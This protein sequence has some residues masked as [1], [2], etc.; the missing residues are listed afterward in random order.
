[1]TDTSS[2]SRAFTPEQ[3]I[4]FNGP[5]GRRRSISISLH[6]T[7]TPAVKSLSSLEHFDLPNDNSDLLSAYDKLTV[8]KRTIEKHLNRIYLHKLKE[9]DNLLSDG[10]NHIDI[11][12]GTLP[13]FEELAIVTSRQHII[14]HTYDDIELNHQNSQS[15]DLTSNNILLCTSD[16]Y[17]LIYDDIKT[18]LIL[19]NN[20]SYINSFIWD[21]NE[22]G[23]PCDLTYSYYLDLYCIITNRGLFTW[24]NE[25]KSIP[26]HIDSIR[27]ISG[28]RLWTIAS[29]DTKSDVFILFKLGSY[30]ERWNSIVGTKSWQHIQRWSNHDLFERNDQ[31]IRTIRMTSNYVV[32][33]V[34]STKTSEW[35][36]DLL[37]YHLQVL[38]RGI[39]ID[40]LD[41]YSSCLLSNFGPEQFL[42]ID[43]NCHSLFLL[44]SN[45]SIKLKTDSII[46]KRIKNAVLMNNN[47]Q[48]WLVVRLERP[49]QLYFIALSDKTDNLNNNM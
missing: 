22:Y 1:M 26:L 37:D 30:I 2:T 39:N 29:T 38:R 14:D 7:A 17:V 23:D 34:E 13:S 49:D 11:V 40:N 35:R 4:R 32:W 16:R 15:F 36:V 41:K 19:Y 21:T 33:T 45:G 27:S 28:N 47:N 31:R 46:N 18:K 24:S 9:I 44:D 25:N 6:E 20:T 42:I 5:K 8:W 10:Q 3:N 43:S 12:F 48:K